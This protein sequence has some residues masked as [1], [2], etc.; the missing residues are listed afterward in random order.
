M[1][2]LPLAPPASGKYPWKFEKIEKKKIL[3]ASKK[4]IPNFQNF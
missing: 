2:E 3:L 4:I 1:I